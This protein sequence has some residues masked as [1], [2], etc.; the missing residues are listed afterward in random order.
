M[1]TR[2]G[3]L[4]SQQRDLKCQKCRRINGLRPSLVMLT[5]LHATVRVSAIRNVLPTAAPD[6]PE[7]AAPAIATA[8][9]SNSSRYR[10]PSPRSHC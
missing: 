2:D 9:A 7:T 8:T 10:K 5:F 1:C 3:Y 6:V 4:W